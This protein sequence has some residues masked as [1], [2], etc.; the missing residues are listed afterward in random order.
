MSGL[1]GLPPRAQLNA[2]VA[3]RVLGTEMLQSHSSYDAAYWLARSHLTTAAVISRERILTCSPQPLPTAAPASRAVQHIL[4]NSNVSSRPVPTLGNRHSDIR[5]SNTHDI[6]APKF[7]HRNSVLNTRRRRDT[8]SALVGPQKPPERDRMDRYATSYPSSTPKPS[9][10]PHGTACNF[11]RANLFTISPRSQVHT[12]THRSS[13]SKGSMAGLGRADER[14][15]WRE[16][17]RGTVPEG[18]LGLSVV[19]TVRY[20]CKRESAAVSASSSLRHN[21]STRV[22]VHP[23]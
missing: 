12:H 7:C 13:S 23:S 3:R 6:R 14:R 1:S 2:A 16:D 15:E 10:R 4:H 17:R 18:L 9:T 8:V 19:L 20:I 11:G 5:M 21:A 22:R